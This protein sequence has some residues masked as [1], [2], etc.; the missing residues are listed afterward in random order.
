MKTLVTGMLAAGML[1]LCAAN[2]QAG[3]AVVLQ[4]QD[5]VVALVEEGEAMVTAAGTTFILRDEAISAKAA[6]L[7]GR[8]A[9]ILYY[10]VAE[11]KCCV[12]IRP[13]SQPVFDLNNSR[14]AESRKSRPFTLK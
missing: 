14:D 12:D 10:I 11:K 13:A 7:L 3:M 6:N 2:L 8:S 9:H 5:G 4:Q 1:W